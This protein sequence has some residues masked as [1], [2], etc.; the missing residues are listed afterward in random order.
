MRKALIRSTGAFVPEWSVPNSYFNELL[1]ED[2]D[3][4]LQ[5]N[6]SIRN[7]H[8][9]SATEST[10]DLAEAAAWDA[11]RKADLRPEKLDLIITQSMI[12]K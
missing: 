2:V 11:L 8:W 3:T 6:L 7:R 5:E 4:W 10:A 1:N 12:I 9:C